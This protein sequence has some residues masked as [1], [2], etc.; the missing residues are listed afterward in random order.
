MFICDKWLREMRSR[1]KT[2]LVEVNN[3]KGYRGVK[4]EEKKEIIDVS[5]EKFWFTFQKKFLC[6]VY[7]FIIGCQ[8]WVVF[9]GELWVFTILW[10]YY[11]SFVNELSGMNANGWM[12]RWF[13]CSII[14]CYHIL[15]WYLIMM[16]QPNPSLEEKSMCIFFVMCDFIYAW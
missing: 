8:H 16:T 10:W 15:S 2:I 12:S 5:Y 13:Q 6:M 11:H 3:E 14:D 4:K 7:L 1:S 9:L